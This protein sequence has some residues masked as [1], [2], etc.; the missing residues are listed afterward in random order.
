MNR[1]DRLLAKCRS[2]D[3]F[4]DRATALS[5]TSQKGMLFERLAKTAKRPDDIPAS[6]IKVYKQNWSGWRDWL[7]TEKN[8]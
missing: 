7:G 5:P 4:W 3:D 2:W 1:M 8:T 6:P